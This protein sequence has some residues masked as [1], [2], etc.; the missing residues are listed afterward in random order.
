MVLS[1]NK[2]IGKKIFR[3]AFAIWKIPNKVQISISD[4]RFYLRLLIC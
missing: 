2:K 3:Q 1:K 4:A